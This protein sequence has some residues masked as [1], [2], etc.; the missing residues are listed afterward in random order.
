MLH[1]HRLD[2]DQALAGGDGLAVG[3]LDQRHRA[4]HGRDHRPAR[5]GRLRGG[6][7]QRGLLADRPGLAVAAQ[8]QRVPVQRD[9]IPAGHPV[10]GHRYRQPRAAGPGPGSRQPRFT[11]ARRDPRP[12]RLR[13][14]HR[15]D[16]V[17]GAPAGPDLDRPCASDT[18]AVHRHPPGRP[19]RLADPPAARHVERVNHRPGRLQRGQRQHRRGR[20]HV[21]RR[22]CR[23]QSR[24]P[25]PDQPGVQMPGPHVGIG[26]QRPQESHVR[27]QPEHHRGAQGGVQPGQRLGPVGPVGDHLG[28]H[29]VVVAAHHAARGDPG[30]DPRP[31][32]PAQR[33]NAAAGGQEARRRVL[34]VDPG[35]DRVTAGPALGGPRLPL[36]GRH[37]QL[38]LD[39]VQAEDLLGDR[40]L[41]LEPG[42]HLHE[43]ELLRPVAAHDELHRPGPDVADRAGRLDRGGAHGAA[44]R[45][46]QQRR[47]RLLD[48]LLVPPLQRA[49]ALAQVD[50]VPVGVGQD[51]DLDVPGVGHQPLD[52][53]RVVPE[54]AP[55]LAPGR[56]DR[57]GQVGGPVHLAHALAAAAGARLEQHRVADLHRSQRQRLVVQPGPVGSGHHRHARLGHGLLGPDLVA[58]RLDGRRRRADERDPG[59]LARRGE[60]GVLRQE[61]VAGMDGLRAGPPGRA[62]HGIHRQVGRRR[63]QVHGQVS[64]RHVRRGRVRVGVHGHGADAEPPQGPDHPA[65]DLAA[66]GHQHG[67][68]HAHPHI[69]KTPKAGSPSGALAAADSASPRTVRVSFGSITPSSHSR[70]V[71]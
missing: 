28:Q 56:G 33:Q 59:R 11:K 16:R 8:P 39:Q 50:G 71:E 17:G 47:G 67:A 37:P 62:D 55:G 53:Q 57:V 70:A 10:H 2:H 9:G 1:L 42:V 14:A 24:Q 41:H 49:L 44:L 7:L 4:R 45:F 66:V 58:H 31:V 36:P 60:H 35:L 51:L 38:Q 3:H 63:A 48:D 19:G 65:G 13:P 21:G 34:G 29:R 5:P 32:R 18:A 25:A 20:Q 43:E 22:P 68:E 12:H 69:R 15:H 26:Q 52:Q 6:R 54:A 40:V 23:R 46:I 61:A 30:V 27:A 64:Q